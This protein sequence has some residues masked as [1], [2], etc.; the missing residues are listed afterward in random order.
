MTFRF[1]ALA[2]AAAL[3]AVPARAGE[4][5]GG[6][7]DTQIPWSGYW[8]PHFRG[9]LEAPALKYDQAT[10][11]Q[12]APW[13]RTHHPAK[14]RITGLPVPQWYGF[15]HA[16]AAA[17]V[18]EREP[19]TPV[20]YAAAGRSPTDFTVGDLK[21]LL[22]ACHAQDVA[23]VYGGRNEGTGPDNDIAPDEL[24]R[25]L[26]LYIQQQHIPLIVDTDPGVQVWNYPIYSYRVVF[27]PVDRSGT[28]NCVLEIFMADDAVG[29]DYLG[30]KLRY[31]RY[32]FTCRM[33]GSNVIAGSGKWTN[34]NHHPDFAWYP[35]LAVGENP[36][37]DYA[38]VK[39]ILGPNAGP[40]NGGR[41][42]PV[43]PN[44][45]PDPTPNPNPG[46]N[47]M[48]NPNPP[49]P[50][51]TII[52]I[53]PLDLAAMIVDK[54]SAFG[55]DVYVDKLDGGKYT[56]DEA[57]RVS[58]I[59]KKAGYLYLFELSPESE[60]API[61]KPVPDPVKPDQGK[62]DAGKPDRSKPRPQNAALE[63]A[64]IPLTMK[65]LYP[66][67]GQDNRI[68]ANKTFTFPRPTD[69]FV[70][71]VGGPFG[72]HKIKALLTTRPLMI[73]GLE[74]IQVQTK[75]LPGQ[76][77]VQ[78][79]VG[80][81]LPQTQK[82]QL[83]S[84]VTQHLQNKITPAQVQQIASGKPANILGE[85]AQDECP[86]VVIEGGKP[87]PV[88]PDPAKPDQGKPDPTKPGQAKP[89]PAKPPLPPPLPV[90]PRKPPAAER[91]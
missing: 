40:T 7:F 91:S 63:P 36:E 61:V 57:L 72:L 52:P 13:E 59:S 29:P 12:A 87:E 85:F 37:I 70:F 8:W 77:Q 82:Q 45:I 20:S 41:P 44:V 55:F 3:L 88:K 30:S 68:A 80:F 1:S 69:A 2:L 11:K 58:G 43:P 33:S 26:K 71:K 15:C 75:P 84:I 66:L 5:A 4:D 73:A 60:A 34:P 9:G 50:D 90:D 25:L 27:N 10:G 32:G 86:Y 48:P 62:P 35:Y 17:A 53:A 39:K 14:D 67:P 78:T 51:A 22:T 89:D 23:N 54:T 47:P 21:G 18:M 76:V 49:V 74:P 46:P 81:R 38:A 42:T 6:V 79:G 28:N 64:P 83:Q 65:L 19:R 24:W 31:E 16:W 56:V